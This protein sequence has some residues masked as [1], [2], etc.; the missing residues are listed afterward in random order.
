MSVS[1]APFGLKSEHFDVND[2]LNSKNFI[3]VFYRAYVRF[4]D[5][6]PT[7]KKETEDIIK[8]AMLNATIKALER[9]S[10]EHRSELHS[11]EQHDINNFVGP[12]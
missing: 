5:S 9:S 7:E 2:L 8:K 12:T 3:D 6:T 10:K 4:K 1:K 11:Q